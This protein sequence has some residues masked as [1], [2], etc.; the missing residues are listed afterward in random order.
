[1]KI[2]VSNDALVFGAHRFRIPDSPRM[3]GGM[4]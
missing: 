4:E 2:L 3:P 1:M